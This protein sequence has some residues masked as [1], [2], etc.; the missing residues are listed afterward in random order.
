MTGEAIPSETLACQEVWLLLI[1]QKK[2]RLPTC[3]SGAG[4]ASVSV[5]DARPASDVPREAHRF[6]AM[7]APAQVSL[8]N[9]AVLP[10]MQ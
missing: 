10:S 7:I 6:D 2:Q 8:G 9:S 5:E 4:K 1:D 3:P